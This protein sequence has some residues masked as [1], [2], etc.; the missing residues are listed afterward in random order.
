MQ[1]NKSEMEVDEDM[2]LDLKQ[3]R[4]ANEKFLLVYCIKQEV[5]QN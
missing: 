4:D 3:T 2:E 5:L 1:D